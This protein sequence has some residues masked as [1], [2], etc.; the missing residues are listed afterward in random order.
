VDATVRYSQD[1]PEQVC[2]FASDGRELPTQILSR[3]K[4][5]LRILFLAKLPATGF[6]IFD[7]RSSDTTSASDLYASET[8]LENH[9]L[10]V[11]L[12]AEG[13]IA[14]I[15]DKEHHRESLSAPIQLAFL[16][17]KPEKYPAWNMDWSDRQKPPK[18]FLKGPAK[19]RV[20]ESG[21]VRVAIEVERNAQGS[22][23]VERIS[24]AA[25]GA[26]NRVEVHTQIDWQT[27]ESSLK[28]VFPLT[29]ANPLA[30]YDIALGAI[31]RGNNDP[32]KY[33]APQHQWFDLTDINRRYGVAVLNDSKYGSDKPDDHTLRLTLLYTPGVRERT[34]DQASQDVGRHQMQYAIMPHAGDWREAGVVWSA[35]RFNQPLLAFQCRAHPGKLGRCFSLATLNTD[36]VMI[37]AIKK[38]EVGDRIIVRL[39]ELAGRTAKGVKLA[40]PAH[41]AAATE[42]NGQETAFQ[43]GT[44]EGRVLVTDM[45]AFSLRAFALRLKSPPAKVAQP[46]TRL[47]R[48]GF[49]GSA[50]RGNFDG[51][52]RRFASLPAKITSEG[53]NFKLGSIRAG[54][55]NVLSCR[56]QTL[57]IPAGFDRIYFLAAAIGGDQ[58][59]RFT[60]GGRI[61]KMK[62][63][64]WCG[65]IGQWDNRQWGGKPIEL[66]YNWDRKLRRIVPGYI[67]RDPVAWFSP[68][69]VAEGKIQYY[70][71]A[72]L[73]K[74]HID[75]SPGDESLVLPRNP[76]I[77]IFAITASNEAIHSLHP[78]RPLY[79]TLPVNID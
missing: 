51:N 45:E 23:F 10:R 50:T 21:P 44:T 71:Y 78:A 70:K 11:T 37:T 55:K 26:G 39:R 64:N 41:I 54:Q 20:V 52:G 8:A 61:V 28:A 53:I 24:L 43:V 30:T 27:R 48:L 31:E 4:S 36:Q 74:Y 58:F 77:K 68:H 32:K 22:R 1:A 25:G 18:A 75:L 35:A 13:N 17:E 47:L 79:D 38:A 73:F 57:K 5:E 62:T 15:F 56:G 6:A 40:L 2:V 66:A 65:F 7:V 59:D 3:E 76:K 60:V 63:Q 72:Y 12:D 67:K 16:L 34:Q 19:T 46:R 42:V 33:E 69:L 9:R 49:N 29:V 14:S